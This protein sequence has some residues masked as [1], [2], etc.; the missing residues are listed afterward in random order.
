MPLQNVM[1]AAMRTALKLPVVSKFIGARLL[2][3]YVVGR[4]SGRTF[5]VPVAYTPHDGELL[6]GSPFAWGKNLRTGESIEIQL[7]GAR[8]I[9]DVRVI[10]DQAGVIDMYGIIARDN[11]NFANFNHIGYT[12]DGEPDPRDLERAFADGARVFALSPR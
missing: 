3:L 7:Q 9:A 8:R 4:K 1:N 2:T 11:R 5:E 12:P 6:V 10:D